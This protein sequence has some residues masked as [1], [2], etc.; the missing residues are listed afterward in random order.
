MASTIKCDVV[1]IES[2]IF[3]G[4]IKLLVAPGIQGE[5]GITA[6]HA[7]LL[8]SLR[9]GILRIIF[10]DE[11]EEV[12]YISGGFLEVQPSHIE[13]LADSAVHGEHILE[14][15]VLKAKQR[16]A[17]DLVNQSGSF[18]YSQALA[19]LTETSA[20]LQAAKV[21]AAKRKGKKVKKVD[22]RY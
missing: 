11:T 18:D 2:S 3:S 1:S 12:L 4:E 14:G 17:K 20:M 10:E 5:L 8:T 15:E 13:V 16:A 9:P 21:S 19:K 22:T 7:P 6:G